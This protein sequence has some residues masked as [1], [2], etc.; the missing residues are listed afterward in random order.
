[1]LLKI[2]L[3]SGLSEAEQRQAA[4]NAANFVLF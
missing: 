2:D 4:N 3:L 1:M